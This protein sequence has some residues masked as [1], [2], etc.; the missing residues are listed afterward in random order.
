M[1]R[2]VDI[3]VV[4]PAY[5]EADNLVHVIP[6]LAE[7]LRT[8]YDSW[9]ILVVDDGSTDG[10]AGVLEELSRTTPELGWIVHR[11]NRGKSEALRSAFDEVDARLVALMDADGQ[12]DPAELGK[13]QAKLDEGFDLVTGRR[14]VR[15]DRLVKRSTSKL[16]NW[17]TATVSGVD[18][19]DFNSGFK[20]MRSEVAESIDMYGEMH[21]YIPPLAEFAGFRSTE[22]DVN[23]RDRLEGASKFGRAR[24]WRGF[25]DLITVSF[26]T[27]YN[28]RP[29]H[30]IGAA[31]IF[32]GVAGAALLLWMAIVWLSG[33][34]VGSRPA[35]IIGVLLTMVSIQL[36][37][38]GLLAELVIF[39]GRRRP[40]PPVT[41]GG[42]RR[43]DRRSVVDDER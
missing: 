21:R 38:M 3:S 1:E 8:Q 37:C 22:V 6:E 39:E 26:L 30:L 7:V 24:F 18:G 31:G 36:M 43:R 28:A 29:F 19:R 2:R 20:L 10:T 23:H 35:L 41:R 9:E 11:R 32:S 34:P 40:P 15:H 4:L 17:A 42:G 25:F 16:Y 33:D 14:S 27:S 12:D 13:L 5:N